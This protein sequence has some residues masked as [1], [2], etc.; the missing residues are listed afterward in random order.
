VD[1]FVEK[2]TTGPLRGPGLKRSEL[3]WKSGNL[4][5]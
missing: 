4:F 2:K 5:R 3:R 1:P